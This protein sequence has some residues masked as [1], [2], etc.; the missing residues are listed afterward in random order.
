MKMSVCVDALWPSW[1]GYDFI[2]GMEAAAAAA[3]Q[4]I[5]FWG[6][7]NKDI[8]SIDSFRRRTGVKISALCTRFVS[9]V[10]ASKHTEYL[11]GLRETIVVAK[12]LE[13]KTIIT[14]VGNYMPEL[15][16]KQQHQNLVEGLCKAAAILEKEDLTLVFEPLNTAV[17]HKGYYLWSSD[18]A[19]QIVDEV[20]SPHVKMLFDIYHQQIMEGNVVERIRRYADKIGHMHCAGVPGR[21]ELENCE[22]DY[23]FILEAIDQTGY[24]GYVALELFTQ[25]PEAEIERW[26]Q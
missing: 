25:N 5:E 12:K 23:R 18:E 7:W 21:H 2:Q 13:C 26:C 4:A 24:A 15:S 3:A 16:Q 22:L 9:L 19:A 8:D 17:D 14:Q 11:D 10:D 6:W 1:K 20:G